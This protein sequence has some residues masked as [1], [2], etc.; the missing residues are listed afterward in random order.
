MH[1]FFYNDTR[2]AESLDVSTRGDNLDAAP[3]P[4]GPNLEISTQVK[5][6]E[7]EVVLLEHDP[8]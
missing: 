4:D 5:I 8:S 7:S 6:P 2:S 1:V 3:T